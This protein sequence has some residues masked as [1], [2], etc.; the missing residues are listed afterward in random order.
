MTPEQEL[1]ARS[2]AFAQIP[3]VVMDNLNQY[4]RNLPDSRFIGA[5]DLLSYIESQRSYVRRTKAR[6]PATAKGK[7]V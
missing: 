1:D 6:G 4:L 7:I 5:S 3:Q 2:A